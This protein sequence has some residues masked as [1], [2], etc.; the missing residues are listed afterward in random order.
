MPDTAPPAQTD[1]RQPSPPQYPYPYQQ[2][3]P[4]TGLAASVM[5][6]SGGLLKI[7]NTVSPVLL[8]L[9]ALV[10]MCGVLMYGLI[11]V[12]PA[13]QQEG[14]G[15]L[16]RSNEDQRELDRVMYRE[17]RD[18]DRRA[19]ASRERSREIRDKAMLDALAE[20]K[21]AVVEVRGAVSKWEKKP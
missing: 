10:G 19:E 8:A 16:N 4:P 5:R 1:A 21:T 11:F 12:A 6:E 3:P 20:V 18:K 2:E 15:Q 7:A 9:L 17:E 14:I 13:M